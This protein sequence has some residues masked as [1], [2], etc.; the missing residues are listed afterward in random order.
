M[1]HYALNV[2]VIRK[3]KFAQGLYTTEQLDRKWEGFDKDAV[4]RACAHHSPHCALHLCLPLQKSMHSL[5][6][7]SVLGTRSCAERRIARLQG[8]DAASANKVAFLDDLHR[9][10]EDCLQQTFDCSAKQIVRGKD[11]VGA[12]RLL[13]NLARAGHV[14][15]LDGAAAVQVRDVCSLK[16][17]V[18]ACDG[19]AKRT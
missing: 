10:L 5:R 17:P 11:P 2:Q 4:V 12:N 7:P 3:T 19:V 15:A 9:V 13:Q 1:S 18:G 6:N 16:Q 14:L 8:K